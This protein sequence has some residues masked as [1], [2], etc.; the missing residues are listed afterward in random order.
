MGQIRTLIVD[1]QDDIRFLLR[2]LIDLADDGLKVV[3]E[4]SNG[5]EALAQA[6]E[7]N[8]VVIVLDEMMPEMSGLETARRLLASRPSQI[9]VLCSA[10][11]DEKVRELAREAGI[12]A[13]LAKDRVHDLPE[14]IRALALAPTG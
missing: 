4:A 2:T 5:T 7:C 1:D 8:P 12:K 9:M 13:C 10:Y 6:K 11:L 3:A 14:L